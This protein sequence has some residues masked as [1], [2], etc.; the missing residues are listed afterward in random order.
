MKHIPFYYTD[1]DFPEFQAL[2]KEEQE[3]LLKCL[4][5]YEKHIVDAVETAKYLYIDKWFKNY[6]GGT[7]YS[8]TWGKGPNVIDQSKV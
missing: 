8:H 4:K 2:P 1:S 7:V 6:K 5:E 3:D